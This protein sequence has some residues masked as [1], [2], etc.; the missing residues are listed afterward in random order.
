MIIYIYLENPR[1]CIERI[2]ERVLNGGHFVPDEAVIRRYFR[3]K[4]KFWNVYKNIADKWFLIYNSDLNFKEICAGSRT[5]YKIHD[6]VMH[7]CFMKD[8]EDE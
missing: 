2:N 8:V 4:N 5:T 7:K 1:I 3:S 6:I